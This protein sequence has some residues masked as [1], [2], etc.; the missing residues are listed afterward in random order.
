M[1]LLVLLL[2][3]FPT[4][5]FAQTWQNPLPLDSTTHQI[6]YSGVVQVAGATQSELYSRAQEWLLGSFKTGK[7]SIVTQD[8]ASGRLI[9]E[10]F[11][12]LFLT[13]AGLAL[14]HRL[15]RTIKVEVKDGRYRYELANYAISRVPVNAQQPEAPGKTSLET[16]YDPAR[17]VYMTKKGQPKPALL[18]ATESI[19]EVSRQQVEA[20][21]QAMQQSKKDW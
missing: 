7:S 20:L 12:P 1:K 2:L 18:K 3:L 11:S 21:K 10:G 9:A 16:M 14:E 8:A 13:Q 17:S 6:T 4:A 5:S 19:D 15:W